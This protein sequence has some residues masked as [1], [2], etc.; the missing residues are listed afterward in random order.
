[1]NDGESAPLVTPL[2]SHP[3]VAGQGPATNN[4]SSTGAQ[5][6]HETTAFAILN[7]PWIAADVA[8]WPLKQARLDDHLQRTHEKKWL[9]HIAHKVHKS[10][11]ET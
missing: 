4:T 11:S 8:M 2:S 3:P 5:D 1:V 10:L 7:N 9:G 6:P